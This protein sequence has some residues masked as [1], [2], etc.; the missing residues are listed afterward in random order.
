M[1]AVI[2]CRA[3]WLLFALSISGVACGEPEAGTWAMR[4]I[5]RDYTFPARDA[6]GAVIPGGVV[7]G[8]LDLDEGRM[9]YVGYCASCHGL[10]GDGRGSASAGLAP[11]PRD[12]RAATFKFAAVR[13]GELPGDED[14]LRLIQRGSNGTVM[15][16]WGLDEVELRRVVQFIK[17][18][19]PAGCAPDA[20]DC[21]PE[22]DRASRWVKVVREGRRRGQ[23]DATIGEAV[24]VTPDPWKGREEEAR[25][26]GE[27]VYHRTAQ[28]LSCHPS[29]L[30]REE[31]SAAA[32][33]PREGL[34]RSVPLAADA[35]PFGV[36][37]LPPDFTVDPLR[38]IRPGHEGEDLYRVIAAGVGG[39]M[40]AWI[41]ALRQEQLWALVH[42]V[43]SL[44]ALEGPAR[45]ALRKKLGLPGDPV[46]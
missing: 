5:T 6:H 1:E 17:T 42:Y 34:H 4:P 40:P 39:V 13:S 38:S 3:S 32:A 14:L 26:V 8:A 37:I 27:E 31:L 23:I 43:R 46:R 36:E 7:I 20:A 18:F 41:D 33:S 29:Y 11:P 10:D 15:P 9:A 21:A 35:N 22:G 19:P 12:F 25:R 45:A 2:G 28:C 16:A 24:S 44:A 30:S